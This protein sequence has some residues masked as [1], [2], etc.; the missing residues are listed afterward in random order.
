MLDK[1]QS[2]A[3]VNFSRRSC[4]HEH[5]LFLQLSLSLSCVCGGERSTAFIY[6]ST[7]TCAEHTRAIPVLL[8]PMYLG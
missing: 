3:P 5:F 2:Y 6:H 7:F 4:L 1:G 8:Y